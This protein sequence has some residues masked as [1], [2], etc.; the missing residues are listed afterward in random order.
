MKV[1]TCIKKLLFLIFFLNRFVEGIPQ[2]YCTAADS[3]F[4]PHLLNLIGSMHEHNSGSLQNIAVFNLGLN[5][6]QIEKLKKIKKVD[7]YEVEKTHPDLLKY[8]VRCPSGRKSR[9]HYAWKPVVIKQALD[10]FPYVLYL[11]A[12][13][14]I[15]RN[16][17]FLFEHIKKKGYFLVAAKPWVL[18]DYLTKQVID[19][20]EKKYRI[21]KQIIFASDAYSISAGTQG[22]SRLVYDDYVLPMYELSKNLALFEDD[23]SAKLGFGKGRHDQNLFSILA[24]HNKYKLIL[25]TQYHSFL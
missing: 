16:A 25:L 15:L 2:F 18:R 14:T 13:T 21:S 10:M 6:N 11:D 1:W 12:G 5:D 17:D 20:V 3:D 7:V 19:L 9:G 22:L 23:G 4:F 8:F 24:Y